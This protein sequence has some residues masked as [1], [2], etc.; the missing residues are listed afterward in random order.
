MSKTKS[1]GQKLAE[2]KKKA[3]PPKKAAAPT[4]RESLQ[5]EVERLRRELKAADAHQKQQRKLADEVE[6]CQLDLAGA[7]ARR[8]AAKEALAAANS[9]LAAF[10]RGGMPKDSE[11]GKQQSIVDEK[12]KGKVGKLVEPR[13]DGKEAR[14]AG[15]K[16]TDN[17]W[18]VDE[19]EHGQWAA[20]Y[21]DEAWKDAE[22]R[23]AST[24]GLTHSALMDALPEGDGLPRGESRP[25]VA[26]VA[27]L[28]SPWLVVDAWRGSEK[29]DACFAL[30]QLIDKDAWRDLWQATYGPPIDD[31]DANAE[32][33]AKRQAGGIDCGRVVRLNGV[34][35]D[36]VVSPERS[37]C[38]VV[39]VPA[40]TAS[41]A[42]AAAANATPI[43]DAKAAAA[44]DAGDDDSDGDD[45]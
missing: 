6:A 43:A 11:T 28:G 18:K 45:E 20:G 1:I 39:T 2:S 5:Q 31:V 19:A 24:Y 14:A 26:H 30:V 35:G 27:A 29:D 23:A 15:K 21:L 25:K 22:R 9:R 32:A 10:V 37:A 36:F 13:R 44:G 17:P 3:K 38:M 4:R 41:K 40:A 7:S 12:P 33:Q 34:R 16:I 8:H 42:L